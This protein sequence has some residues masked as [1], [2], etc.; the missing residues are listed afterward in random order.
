MERCTPL[1]RSDTGGEPEFRIRRPLAPR[2]RRRLVV[3]LLCCG[4]LAVTR[5]IV[6]TLALGQPGSPMP[7]PYAYLPSPNCDERPP[8]SAISCIVLHATVEPTTQRTEQIFL[9]PAR[10]VSAHFIV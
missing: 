7:L 2:I 9:T 3:L 4:L 6:K 8:G 5:L 1:S 10:G